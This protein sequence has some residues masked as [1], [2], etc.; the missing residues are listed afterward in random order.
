MVKTSE[1]GL[2]IITT[3]INPI[4]IATQVLIETL[5]FKINTDNTTIIIGANAPILWAFAKDKYLKDKTKNP[6]S[7]ICLL[8]TSP[9]PRD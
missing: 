6:D 1:P 3:P 8:Y 4:K 5:S 7:K 9:S 2:I